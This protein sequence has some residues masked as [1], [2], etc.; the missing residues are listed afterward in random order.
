MT[1]VQTC[2]LP[3][4]KTQILNGIRK[5]EDK[6]QDS[7][8]PKFNGTTS[9]KHGSITKMIASTNK[10]EKRVSIKFN[11]RIKAF[12]TKQKINLEQKTVKDS[13]RKNI[14]DNNSGIMIQ[15]YI[16]NIKGKEQEFSQSKTKL[17]QSNIL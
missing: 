6:K 1:G 16:N 9:F 11:E 13:S 10:N 15:N 5:S 7:D 4:L 3:I 2:A 8:K 12:T 14:K 17:K